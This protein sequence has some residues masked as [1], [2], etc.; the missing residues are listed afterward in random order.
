MRIY[1][2][3]ILRNRTGTLYVGVT[4]DLERRLVEHRLGL[5]D[6]F[7]KR[8]RINEV[9]YFEE[10]SDVHVALARERQIKGWT[11]RRKAALIRSTNPDWRDL[12]AEWFGVSGR[13]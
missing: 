5:T 6:G 4:N 8:Y 7:T 9:V 2:V 3:Y 1:Y 11:R 13:S 12:A 10:T